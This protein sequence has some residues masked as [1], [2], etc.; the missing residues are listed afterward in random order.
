MNTKPIPAVLA[1]V[2]GFII[3]IMSFVQRVDTV[4]FA[5]RFIIV[6]LIFFVFGMIVKVVLDKNMKVSRQEEDVEETQEK[7]EIDDIKVVDKE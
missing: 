4:I 1:L 5:K 2:A 3:C 6:C 7:E